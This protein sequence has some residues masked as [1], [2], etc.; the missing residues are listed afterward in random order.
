MATQK[1]TIHQI[2]ITGD[3]TIQLRLALDFVD[4]DGN[5]IGSREPRYHRTSFP[6]DT[7]IDAQMAAV[8]AHLKSFGWPEVSDYTAIK[9]Y[10]SVAW[11]K[12]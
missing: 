4:D 9:G 12:E 3:K 1:T 5:V 8:N 2:E 7:P 6:L 10:S 11:A